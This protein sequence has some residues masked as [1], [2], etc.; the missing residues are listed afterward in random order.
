LRI[1]L[2]IV[3]TM[4]WTATSAFP[5]PFARVP[6]GSHD[7]VKNWLSYEIMDL[8][9]WV[10]VADL[11]NEFRQQTLK[12]APIELGAAT[13]LSDLEVPFTYLFP[14]SLIPKPAEWGPHI[15]LANFI[16]L[17]QAETYTPPPDLAAFLAAGERP[18]CVGFGSTVVQDPV[19][20]TRTIFAA[21]AQAGARGIVLRGWGHL[22]GEA[23]P[24]NVYV[25]DDCP[26]DWLF[27]RCRAVCHHGGAGTT[28]AGLRAGLPT[29]V[30]PFFGDQFFWGQVVSAAG[31]GPTPIP[32]ETLDA[33]RL[34]EAFAACGRPQMRAR[35]EELG[36]KIRTTDGVELVVDSLRRHLPIA[37]MQCARDPEHLARVYCERCRLRL[38]PACHEGAHAGHAAHPYRPFN[39]SV[40]APQHLG[41]E[42]RAFAADA[43]H[44]LSAFVEQPR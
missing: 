24:P 13:L 43:L 3:F 34:A 8:L 33:V 17:D 32:I 37:A 22:G 19:A 31:A 16:F 20:T 40:R 28:S 26:H 36:A 44:A 1:P 38:C 41:D 18:I 9:M 39:W 25:I 10:G 4:P 15:D 12:L 14:E 29:V 11:I 23:P 42:L 2:H 35:A 30:V 7:P 6:P 5:H 21:L 27:P